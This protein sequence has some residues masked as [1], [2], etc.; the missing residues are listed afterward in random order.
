[1]HFHTNDQ[2]IA[3]AITHFFTSD[4][5]PAHDAIHSSARLG[6]GM[7][8]RSAALWQAMADDTIARRAVERKGSAGL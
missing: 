6:A 4:R 1:M 3:A 8:K 2:L 7:Q 5:R